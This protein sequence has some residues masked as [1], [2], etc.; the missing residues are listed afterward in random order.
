MD[1]WQLVILPLLVLLPMVLLV[2]F[3]PG[4]ERLN[5][6]GVPMARNWPARVHPAADDEHH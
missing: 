2:V 3:H 6:R 1:P 5:A 4:G